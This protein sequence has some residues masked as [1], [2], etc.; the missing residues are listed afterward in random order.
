MNRKKK[1]LKVK[2]FCSPIIEKEPFEGEAEAVSSENKLGKFDILAEHA[3]F[4]T[5]IFRELTINIAAKK[6]IAYQFEKGVLEV[7]DN[8]VN[9]FL[10]L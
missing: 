9:V 5:L 7:S 10:G 4:I 1:L 2:V 3:N 6:K 8:K